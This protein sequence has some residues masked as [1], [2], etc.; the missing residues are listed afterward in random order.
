M[1]LGVPGRGDAQIISPGR[2]SEAHAELEGMGNCTQCHQLRTPGADPD[3]CLQ[4]HES[5]GRRIKSREGYHGGLQDQYC[6]SCHKE[7][8]GEDFALIRMDPD[9]FPHH[10]TGYFLAG[11]HENVECRTC[12]TP[13]LIVDQE[14]REELSGKGGLERTF[15]GLSQE[16]AVCHSDLDPHAGQFGDRVCSSC[17]T[18]IEWTGA[19]LFDH[20]RSSYPLAG[21]HREVACVDCHVP[22]RSLHRTESIRYVPLDASDCSTCHDN[23]HRPSIPG[24]CSGCHST[25]AWSR[26]NRATMESVFDHS[27]TEFPLVGAHSRAECAVCHSMA[28]SGRVD[29]GISFSG[30]PVGRSYPV[31]VVST[32]TS[33][34]LDSHE[35]DFDGRSCDACHGQEAWVPPD[36][37]RARH[38][39]ELRFE[40]TGAH[41][42]TPCS[43]CH[44]TDAG[45]ER[46]M[47]FR[48]EDPERCAVCHAEEDPHEGTFSVPGCDRCHGTTVFEMGSF[49]HQLL[50]EVEWAGA[51]VT[52]HQED[53]PHSG[54][55][56]ARDCQDCH[57]TPPY[58]IPNFDHTQTRFPLEGAHIE[59]PCGGCHLPEESAT[60]TK[61]IRYRPLDTDCASC[62]GRVG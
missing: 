58:Q 6:G 62:H 40:L 37:E 17:H 20:A 16:C 46:R 23:P 9:T 53:D 59:T 13:G 22:E 57:E 51:C 24:G 14:L 3:R 31:P 12:H 34:H 41:A 50:D 47:V 61:S 26:V 30:S 21:R 54:Q 56:P 60:G 48:F 44:E 10:A 55:F 4:C 7:H 52:C 15:L 1:G 39:M 36:F 45:M 25:A 33:C 2:L 35:G 29:V 8:L 11:A 19:E 18:E 43:A 27:A 32:C 49:D 38:Q 5:L 42:V 28:T